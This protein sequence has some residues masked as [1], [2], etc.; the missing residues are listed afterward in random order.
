ML[1]YGKA[2]PGWG[3]VVTDMKLLAPSVGWAERA[4]RFYWTKDNGSTWKDITPPTIDGERIEGTFFLDTRRGWMTTCRRDTEANA[5]PCDLVSTSDAGATWSRTPIKFAAAKRAWISLSPE[6]MPNGGAGQIA[7]SDPMRGWMNFVLAGSH[8]DSWVSLLVVTSDRG[9]TWK[10]A[11]NA[12]NV[13]SNVAMQLVTPTEGWLY[14]EDDDGD[15]QLY[16]TRDAANSWQTVTLE[17][18][19]E[20]APANC[21]VMGLPTFEDSKHGF[22]RVNCS[23]GEPP[24]SKLAIVLF[25]TEDGGRTW[26][27]DRM[28]K[29]LDDYSRE[30]FRTSAVLDSH[31]IFAALSNHKPMLI[32]LG[33][34]DTIDGA[35][36]VNTGRSDYGA[37]QIS[38]VTPTQGWI[39]IG[40]GELQS[41]TDGGKTWT[42]ISPGPQPHVIH[43]AGN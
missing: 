6:S 14:G 32:Q 34:G 39:I 21:V 9:E 25:A 24:E 1:W 36:D 4:N 16:V 31:W 5:T 18:P 11:P 42:A 7:F 28:V 37:D 22:V 38:F 20:I 8:G 15:E 10:E 30:K 26:K 27:P 19:R 43:P 29:N 12:P 23:S 17:A 3:G 35:A 33:A 40:E 13:G 2:P 41:T